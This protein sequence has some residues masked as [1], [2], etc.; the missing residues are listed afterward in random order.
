MPKEELS[1]ALFLDFDNIFIGLKNLSPEAATAFVRN[2]QTWLEW[3]RAG[4]HSQG[5]PIPRRLLVQ[6]CYLNPDQLAQHRGAFVRAGFEVIDCPAL[7]S[8]N[9]NSADIYMALDIVDL[10]DHRVHIDE[11][12][13]LSA[14]ADFTPVLHRLRLHDR[15]TTVYANLVTAAAYKNASSGLID[16]DRFI[17][18]ALGIGPE[19]GEPPRETAPRERIT[20]PDAEMAFAAHRITEELQEKR[21]LPLNSL[22]GFLKQQYPP[23]DDSE[24]LG[25]GTLQSL[26]DALLKSEPSL[27]LRGDEGAR[28]L[29]LRPVHNEDKRVKEVLSFINEKI[30]ASMTPIAAA[31]LLSMVKAEFSIHLPAV[32]YF[33]AGSMARFINRQGDETLCFDPSPPGN[34]Y[35]PTRHELPEGTTGV[36]T[37]LEGVEQNLAA[38]IEEVS[39][40]TGWPALSPEQLSIM[41]ETG[42]GL[43]AKGVIERSALSKRIRDDIQTRIDDGDADPRRRVARAPI[44]FILTSVIL[45]GGTISE[46]DTREA[47]AEAAWDGFAQLYEQRLEPMNAER[48]ACLRDKLFG[49]PEDRPL[50]H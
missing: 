34:I 38:I 49:L 8:Q 31:R 1:A 43:V 46:A 18:E 48:K 23:F 9:K 45:R 20:D 50:R 12:I 32:N 13:V 7:T 41:F 25:R 35:D 19:A 10:L 30:A 47:F 14:D 22:G 2:I 40:A 15:I 44:T 5:N 4:Q 16:Q 26:V 36:R 37:R 33:G 39:D 21:T 6:R 24:W 17:A 11:F 42:A 3:F 27:E 28:E 29:A